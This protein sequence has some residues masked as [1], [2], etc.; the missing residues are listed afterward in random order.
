MLNSAI[1]SAVSFGFIGSMIP[2]PVV[3]AVFTEILQSSFRRSFKTIFYALLVETSIAFLIV[4]IFSLIPVD[5]RIFSFI[6]LVGAVVL[7]IISRSLWK[8][9]SIDAESQ[10][11]FN[12]SKITLLT[13]TNGL[14]WTYWITVGIPKALELNQSVVHGKYVFLGLMEMGWLLG[15]VLLAFVFSRF[16]PLLVKPKVIGTVFKIFALTFVY[17]AIEMTYKSIVQLM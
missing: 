13:V 6:S 3:S 14:F 17:F 5:E 8:I 7:I 9:K 2:G 10:V 11:S 12:F 16:R 15:T 4:M 1:I